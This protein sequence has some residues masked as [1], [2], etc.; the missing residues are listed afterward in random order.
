M[1]TLTIEIPDKEKD[2]FLQVI[3][4]FNAKILAND[5]NDINTDLAEALRETKAIQQGQRKGLLLKDMK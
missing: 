2:F 4:K 5:I 3:K 1:A